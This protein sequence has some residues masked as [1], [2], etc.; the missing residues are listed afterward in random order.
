[1]KKHQAASGSNYIY[2]Q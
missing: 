2:G 1:V